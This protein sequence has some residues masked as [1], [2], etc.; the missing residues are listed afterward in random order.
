MRMLLADQGQSWKEEVVTLDVWEQGTFKASCL[1]GQ[2]PKFQDGELT[3]Y[4]SNTI[5]RHLGRSF[6]LYGK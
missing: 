4:Q 6:G 2:I 1:F 3:L 5:L